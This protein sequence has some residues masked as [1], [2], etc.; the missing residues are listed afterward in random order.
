MYILDAS[1]KTPLYLQLYE[2][3]KND[4]L[5]KCVVG[6]KLPSVRQ[7]CKEYK[8]SKNTVES[9]Y[10]QLCAEGY[11]TSREK[12]GYFVSDIESYKRYKSSSKDA[13]AS[14]EL[15]EV[16]PKSVYDFHPAKLPNG[17]FPLKTWKK[18]YQK[19][20]TNELAFNAYQ[21]AFGEYK[22][23]VQIA[24]YLYSSRGVACEASQV[25]VCN[26]FTDSLY[27]VAKILKPTHKK[28][29]IEAPGYLPASEVFS[30]F[31]YDISHI[32]VSKNG[33]SIADLT[34]D[35]SRLVYLTPSH[36]F[37]TGCIMPIMSRTKILSWAQDVDGFIIEDDYDSELCYD[38]K[39]IPSLQGLDNDD[40]VIYLGTFSKSLSPSLRISYLILPK[41]LTATYKTRFSRH[42]AKVC[43]SLQA[44]LAMFMELGYWDRHINKVRSV[45]KKRHDLMLQALRE[46]FGDDV[47][48]L[49]HGAGLCIMAEFAK[50][51]DAESLRAEMKKRGVIIYPTKFYSS[52][53]RQDSLLMMGFGGI[54]DVDIADSVRYL[55]A[56][57]DS[58]ILH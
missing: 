26:G 42:S 23:R 40:R 20:V 47:N 27:I 3:I 49:S 39:P 51:L 34:A 21:D 13:N 8:I 46:N 58:F 9:A 25:V 7:I 32:K 14:C 45:V 44:T 17:I 57:M 5:K 12:S 35:D 43:V 19:V 48:I 29:A 4:I 41:R 52:E 54:E 50:I 10:R 28:I 55:K 38:K 56:V 15:C 30:D 22:L 37:P 1:V 18:I 6:D 2:A 24:K 53:C 36:Q 31:G 11:V 33:I 16:A